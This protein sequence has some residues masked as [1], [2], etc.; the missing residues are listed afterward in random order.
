GRN[1]VKMAKQGRILEVMVQ[2][3]HPASKP[4]TTV[5]LVMQVTLSATF[6]VPPLLPPSATCATSKV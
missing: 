4:S 2:L 5:P 3:R 6:V 1:G